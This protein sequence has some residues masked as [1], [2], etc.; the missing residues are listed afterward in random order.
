[1]K[2]NEIDLEPG[3]KQRFDPSNTDYERSFDKFLLDC[4]DSIAAM[5]QAKQL[6]YRGIKTKVPDI[7]VG[8]PR[9]DRSPL[10]T[11]KGHNE[12]INT[13]M[14]K[15]GFTAI[16]TNSI[17]CSG[18]VWE[19]GMYGKNYIIFPKNGFDFTWSTKIDDLTRYLSLNRTNF[20][21]YGFQ[22]YSDTFQK[23]RIA[24][25]NVTSYMRQI[26]HE[27]NN[28]PYGSPER[29]G[30]EKLGGLIANTQNYYKMDLQTNTYMF[31]SAKDAKK[32]AAAV[33]A[34]NSMYKQNIGEKLMDHLPDY[35]Q[36]ATAMQNPQKNIHPKDV[37]QGMGYKSDDFTAALNSLHE[38]LIKGEYYAFNK[39]KYYYELREKI[40]YENK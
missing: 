18:S 15:A 32:I 12:Q 2:I 23:Y 7:F 37:M 21:Q 17:F 16:R 10:D 4:S 27:V 24:G 26:I 30:G 25:F 33:V 38:I 19:T 6:L 3:Q 14:S 13:L 8:I 9:Q 39:D 11:P 20:S 35:I 36:Y 31:P 5:R 40:L 28:L 34:Y 1:M 29:K 22:A